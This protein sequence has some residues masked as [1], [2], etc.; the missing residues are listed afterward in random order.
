MTASAI[1]L[2]ELRGCDLFED[3]NDAELQEWVAAA[4]PLEV[5]EGELLAEYNDEPRDLMLLLEGDV[6]IL[7]IHQ[8]R[9]D[10]GIRHRAPSSLGAIALLTGGPIGV[11]IAARRRC[12]LA[13]RQAGVNTRQEGGVHC[14][15]SGRS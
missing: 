15:S 1:T 11:R 3:L 4:G 12:R 14:E 10:P 9:A 13:L 5:A 7:T 2:V 8:G 6:E